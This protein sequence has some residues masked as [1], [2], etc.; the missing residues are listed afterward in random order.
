M[1][2]N[3]IKVT[4]VTFVVAFLATLS[5]WFFLHPT[6]EESQVVP[7]AVAPAAGHIEQARTLEKTLTGL[8]GEL[9]TLKDEYRQLTSSLRDIETTVNRAVSSE[10][11][12]AAA[13]EMEETDVDLQA[14][15]GATLSEEGEL[16][17]AL[18]DLELRLG[19]EPDDPSWS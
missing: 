12:T 14:G 11:Q 15:K 13:A 4:N 3:V 16:A 9:A 6:E 8:Q 19:K 1:N 17:N 7:A 10:M 18:S 2:R 5:T